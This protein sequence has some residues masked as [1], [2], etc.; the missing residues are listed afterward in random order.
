MFFLQLYIKWWLKIYRQVWLRS[1]S[2]GYL[3]ALPQLRTVCL[4]FTWE[5]GQEGAGWKVRIASLLRVSLLTL[6]SHPRFP[7]WF[8]TILVLGKN[9]IS[10]GVP[11]F[12]QGLNGFCV[13][14][15]AS[16]RCQLWQITQDFS[17]VRYHPTAYWHVRNPWK[18]T[19]LT[20]FPPFH[21]IMLNDSTFIQRKAK[22]KHMGS[23]KICWCWN[24]GLPPWLRR[25]VAAPQKPA[26]KF[27]VE[28]QF[29]S[30]LQELW[31]PPAVLLC[32]RAGCAASASNRLTDKR[33]LPLT[34]SGENDGWLG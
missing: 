25:E 22:T 8:K 29:S 5:V 21:H 26:R 10:V 34:F 33:A 16:L 30:S 32:L 15:K 11:L 27:K 20:V 1:Y 7:R 2:Y 9:L 6:S 19:A 12:C 23:G 24:L 13:S 4:P 14:G 17:N 28:V 18:G 3:T 31:S